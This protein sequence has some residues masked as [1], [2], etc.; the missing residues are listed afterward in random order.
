MKHNSSLLQLTDLQFIREI[1]SLISFQFVIL[2]MASKC[3][4]KKYL[5]Q[6][7][8]NASSYTN[9]TTGTVIKI[10]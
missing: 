10:S 3:S 4:I 6:I 9:L 2:P 8:I 5:S 1:S 7:Q